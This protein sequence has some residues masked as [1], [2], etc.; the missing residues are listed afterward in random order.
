MDF[1]SIKNTGT[2]L[3]TFKKINNLFKIDFLI[4]NITN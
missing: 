2:N 1:K 4:N 3:K